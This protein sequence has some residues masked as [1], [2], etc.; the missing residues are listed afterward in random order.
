MH[1]DLLKK[2][3]T[4]TPKRISELAKNADGIIVLFDRNTM[5]ISQ[6]RCRMNGPNNP[7]KWCDYTWNPVKGKCPVACPYC[8]A[9]RIYDRLKWDP[10]VRLD[11][12][13]LLVPYKL[14]KPTKIFVGSMIELFGELINPWMGDILKVVKGCPQHTFQFLTKVPNVMCDFT[15][16]NNCWCGTTITGY[17]NKTDG[18]LYP[19][20]FVK[21]RIKFLSVEPLLEPVYFSLFDLKQISWMI[22]GAETGNRK[23]KVKP[24][25]DWIRGAIR[26][27]DDCNIPI[28]MKDNLKPYWHGKL[29]QEFP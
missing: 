25:E 22:I 4:R 9:R 26:Q 14:K 16:P 19:L 20:S 5:I 28:F 18:Q 17:T 29:R 13:E 21:A 10:T 8:Y 12:K 23:G 6:K 1:A 27:A 7:I 11:K 24:K 3:I 15:F 2:G